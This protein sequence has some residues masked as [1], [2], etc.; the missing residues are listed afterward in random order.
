MLC[1][2]DNFVTIEDENEV[3]VQKLKTSIFIGVERDGAIVYFYTMRK[4]RPLTALEFYN[5]DSA[6]RI[7]RDF[8]E[9]IRGRYR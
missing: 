2:D 9:I 5:I 3:E 1:Y 7:V 8:N 6:K 4:D